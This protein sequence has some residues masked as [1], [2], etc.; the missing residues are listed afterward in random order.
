MIIKYIILILYCTGKCYHIIVT[1]IRYLFRVYTHTNTY[2]IMT[3]GQWETSITAR[4]NIFYLTAK[5]NLF[6]YRGQ[7]LL[8][9]VSGYGV[10]EVAI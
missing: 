8:F 6:V 9:Y 10:H 2:N 4:Y 3:N 7:Q 1:T 5:P